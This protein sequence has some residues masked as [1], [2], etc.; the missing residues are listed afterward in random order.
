MTGVEVFT[1]NLNDKATIEAA[2]A[3]DVK[4]AFLANSNSREQ[5]DQEKNFIDVAVAKGCPYLVK[6][7]TVASYT[8][9][10]SDT[11]YARHHAV[12]EK[13]LESTAG[14]MKWCVLHPN[15]FMP[16]HLGDIFGTLPKGIIAY[17]VDGDVKCHMVDTRDVSDIAAKLL[18]AN[19][20]SQYHGKHMDIS[21]PEGVSLNEVAQMYTEA[22]GREIKAVKPTPEQW[23]EHWSLCDAGAKGAGFADWMAVAVST[24]F[25]RWES[26]LF[27]FP[28]HP[29]CLA[30]S[31]PKRT[32]KQWV[33]EWAPKSPAPAA[34]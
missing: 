2:F 16:N 23:L 6:L 11:E 13:H 18:T 21:G 34:A 19:D 10:D 20:P 14:S 27:Q 22:L 24:N 4:A 5:G 33:T 8:S 12:A 31:P 32:M 15:W 26:G 7:G 29:D 3:G 9:V 25:P 17:P 28:T 1:C 30:V